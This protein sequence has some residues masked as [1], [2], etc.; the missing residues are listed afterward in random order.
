MFTLIGGGIRS[1][2]ASKRPMKDTLPS[3]AKW[4]ED[5]VISFEPTQ[6]QVTMSNG[7]TVEY[8]I[9]IVAV[10]LQLYWEKIP[11]LVKS[12][13][14]GLSQVCSIYGSDTVVNVFP[15]IART[16]EGTA[17]FTFPNS[18]V[19][20]PGAPQK[21]AYIAE[22]YFRKK[23]VRDNVKVVYNTALPVIFGVKKYADS[24]WDVCKQRNITVNVQTNL[25]EID[26]VK[27]EAVFQKLDGSNETFVEKYSLLHVCPPMGPPD[28]LKKHPSLTNEVGFLTVDPKT[29]RHTK[30]P[31]IYGIGDCTST[32][33][34]KTMAAIAAQGKVLY[35]NIIDDLAGKPM[36]MAYNGYSSCP[37]VTGYNKCILAEFDYNLQPLET[38]PVNQ[39][40][41]YFFTYLLKTYVFPLL[42]WNLMTR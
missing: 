5:N 9:M 16:Q 11:G 24:L 39:G 14:D 13:K 12:L 32:P 36:T 20:C 31:N 33:N 35:K 2:E 27:Q 40:R 18:P 25:V 22:D 30:Y 34:S 6:N 8:E 7:D 17:I 21:I 28:V 15:K 38:F 29:L 37:L 42:Y 1:L 23:K 41:E 3:N 19:K 26:P 10:G 4:F